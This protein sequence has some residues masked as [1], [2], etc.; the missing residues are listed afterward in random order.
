M[1]KRIASRFS[2]GETIC[3]THTGFSSFF[4]SRIYLPTYVFNL[5]CKQCL[6]L[7]HPVTYF[8]LSVNKGN[9]IIELA[10][11]KVELQFHYRHI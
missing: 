6:K 10:W 2:S 3:F 9:L 4:Y 5:I 1:L 8:F 7:M 11:Y